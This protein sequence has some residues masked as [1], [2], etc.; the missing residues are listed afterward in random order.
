M[1]GHAADHSENEQSQDIVDHCGS[2]N[3]LAC[4]FLQ[5]AHEIEDL[6]SDTDAG[7]NQ[8]SSYEDCFDARDSGH[9]HDGPSE[10]ERNRYA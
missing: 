6:Y 4:P 1:F 9:R 7:C 8:G 10:H 2:Q 5:Q 3:G